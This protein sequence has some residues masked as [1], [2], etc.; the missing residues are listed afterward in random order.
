V[1][2]WSLEV[3]RAALGAPARVTRYEPV[4]ARPTRVCVVCGQSFD[5]HRRHGS[6]RVVCS[7]ACRAARDRE[8]ARD[9]YWRRRREGGT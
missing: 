3:A 7:A 8:L 5:E 1:S 2:D 9:G 4:D 6:P